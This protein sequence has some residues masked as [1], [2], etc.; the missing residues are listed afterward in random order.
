MKVGK[1]KGLSR[2][3]LFG[4]AEGFGPALAR[5]VVLVDGSAPVFEA[6]FPA[7]GARITELADRFP[8]LKAPLLAINERIVD[9]LPVARRHYYHPSQQGSWGLKSVLPTI[10]TDISYDKLVRSPGHAAIPHAILTARLQIFEFM[11]GCS[12]SDPSS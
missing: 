10:A 2:A 3:R 7:E 6:G 4:Q 12:K 5:S 1:S 11:N 9:L 8:R